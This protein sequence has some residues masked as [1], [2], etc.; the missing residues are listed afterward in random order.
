[1]ISL[2]TVIQPPLALVVK[3][4]LP[5]F[6]PPQN[7]FFLTLKM[8]SEIEQAVIMDLQQL[9]YLFLIPFIEC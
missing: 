2:E 1:M 6:S 4:L 8:Q 7:Y 3:C 5:W 9:K